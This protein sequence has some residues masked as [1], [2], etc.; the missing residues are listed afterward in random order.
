MGVQG[1]SIGDLASDRGL[2]LRLASCPTVD[3]C[4]RI[5]LSE[6]LHSWTLLCDF[7]TSYFPRHSLLT[8]SYIILKSNHVW[9]LTIQLNNNGAS[10]EYVPL[11]IT[12]VYA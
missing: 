11:Y 4:L 8:F 5:P 12:D 6:I 3:Q 2:C 1:N 9:G 10:V 7:G